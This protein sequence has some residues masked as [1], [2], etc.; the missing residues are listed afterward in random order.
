MGP[1]FLPFSG[2][3]SVNRQEKNRACSLNKLKPTC[4]NSGTFKL[5]KLTKKN[6]LGDFPLASSNVEWSKTD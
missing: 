3:L 1:H 5:K 2:K 4:K 6:L